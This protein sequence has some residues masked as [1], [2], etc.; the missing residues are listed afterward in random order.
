MTGSKLKNKCETPKCQTTAIQICQCN[1][2]DTK[3]SSYQTQ[4]FIHHVSNSIKYKW[5]SQV[6]PL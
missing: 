2:T 6:Q 3:N 5:Q 4:P 1:R